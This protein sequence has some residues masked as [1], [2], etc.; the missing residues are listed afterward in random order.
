MVNQGNEARE[1]LGDHTGEAG[2]ETIR[3]AGGSQGQ[4]EGE[5]GENEEG[6]EEMV[7]EDDLPDEF[8]M[9]EGEKRELNAEGKK[10]VERLIRGIAGRVS[11][12]G[13]SSF[14]R[15]SC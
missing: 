6:T 7:L 2:R 9:G 10:K 13:S 1:A 14:E 8:W 15:C 4:A 5:E 12:S 3:A 11:L